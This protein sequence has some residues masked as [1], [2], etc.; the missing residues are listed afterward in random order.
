MYLERIDSPQDLKRLSVPELEKLA[1]EIREAIIEVVLGKTGGHFAPNLGTVE[2]TL[3]LHYVFD[4]PRDKIVWDVGHQAYPHKLVTGRRDRFHT[5]R[6]EGGL[7]G[8]LQREESPHDHFGAGHASTSISAALGMAVAAKL[9]GERYHTIAVIGDGALT[10]GMAYEA[11]NHAGAL[12]VPLI[13]VLN[14][15]EMSIAPNVGALARYL[16]R[17]R[18][19]TRYR[20]AKVEIE[21]LLRRLPQGERLV[22]LSYRFLDGLK[23]V[24]YR[25][26]IWEELGFTYIGPID[27]HNL[28]ELIETF[29]L[30]KTFDSPVF[31]HVLTVKGKGYQPAEDDPFKH[32]SAAVKVP[33]APPTPPRY[34]DVFGHTL[35]ELAAKNDRI[36]AI[37]A[38]MPDG[39]GLLP[40]AA[41]YPD[42]FFD[43]GIAEQHAVTFAAG[44]ATQGLRP[45][46]AIYSTFL[47]RAYDQVIHDVCIQKLPVV[48]AMDR[49]GLVGEDGRTHHGVFDVAYLRCLPNMVLMAPKDEDEL[50]HMLATALAY[51]EGPIALRYPRGS[52]VGVPML[53][54]PRVLPIGRAELLREGSD[55]AIVALGATVLPAERAADILAERGIRATVINARFVKPLDRSL[56]LDAAR[57]CGCLVTVEEAQLAGGFGSAVLETLA[58]AGLLSPVLRLG[59]AD[60][61]FDHASQASLRRQAGID[62][63]SIASRTLAFLATHGRIETGAIS[64]R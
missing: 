38:A 27:G 18:T 28:R 62:A 42:R 5:I 19:D 60:R 63:E 44:L 48:F 13:V 20:Q 11:L 53:G 12:Q 25:T 24:V 56:I 14:D 58:D 10:G 8:F 1:E 49:A 33:G 52:G 15:N 21:R 46:C 4:S 32:H 2:L 23:E 17:V 40:F 22:E 41:A 34:Q 35:V 55:V 39:T 3:A 37:T 29:Q 51:E 45:V 61:F 7:S 43:V 47:Q 26:M 31:V 54:E 30:V 50:R 6:Q 9:R 36:V 57:E 59:L 64:D 16:T